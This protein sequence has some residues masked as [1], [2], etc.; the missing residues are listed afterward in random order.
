MSFQKTD[1]VLI[2]AALLCMLKL[3]GFLISAGSERSKP[4]QN[5]REL[6]KLTQVSYLRGWLSD[7][8]HLVIQQRWQSHRDLPIAER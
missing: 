5:Q 6:A 8:D 4:S 1:L 7:Y 2:R 3:L